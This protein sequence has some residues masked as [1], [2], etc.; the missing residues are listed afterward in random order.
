MKKRDLTI[1]SFLLILLGWFLFSETLHYYF[2]SDDFIW[3]L[4]AK[5]D[6]IESVPR[7]LID[8]QGFFYRPFTKAYFFF[9]WQWA[10]LNPFYY[11]SVNV[12]IHLLN[13]LLVYF[14]SIKILERM[15]KGR[16]SERFSL[17]SAVSAFIFFIHPVHQENILWISAVTELF[18][19][20]FIFLAFNLYLSKVFSYT[21]TKILFYLCFAFALMS[22]EY[23]VIF[24]LVI[25]ISDFF[26][27]DLGVKN[28][29]RKKGFFY[30]TLI[31]MDAI[32][33]VLRS[34]ANSHWSGGD[35]SYNLVKLPFNFVGNLVGYV[36]L[37]LAGVPFVYFYQNIRNI[38]RANILLSA[39][40]LAVFALACV[41]LIK[42]ARNNNI[43]QGRGISKNMLLYLIIIFILGLLPFLG[44]GGI[45]ERYLYFPSYPFI[46]LFSL[47]VFWIIRYFDVDSSQYNKWYLGI[48]V[49]VSVLCIYSAKNDQEDWRTASNFVKL[50]LNEF[51]VDCEKYLPGQALTRT[52]PPNRVGR[53]WVFQVG[54]EQ[55]ANLLCDKNI[56]IL[57]K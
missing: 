19:A 26:L 46:L 45:A 1:L 7:Y 36:G 6:T 56:T 39:A 48:I 5:R 49:L 18:P 13:S 22:H 10:G 35:Y 30:F 29:L 11:H 57:L 53:A 34:T 2:V 20:L 21:L 25:F 4:H 24:P 43:S 38:M 14:L 8:A 47:S 15:S 55:G 28:L 31:L 3:L 16:S 33:L 42:L 50:R 54:Y 12:I 23:A 40:L 51:S 52:S 44:L 41:Y 32:Y 27:V 37:N 9:M 17:F